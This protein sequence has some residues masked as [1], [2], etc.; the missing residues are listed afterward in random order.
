MIRTIATSNQ[1]L[2]FIMIAQKIDKSK[3]NKRRNSKGKNKIESCMLDPVR[4]I[5]KY[6]ISRTCIVFISAECRLTISPQI[7]QVFP[8]HR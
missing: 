7:A 8:D 1:L 6:S 4:K 5:V 2:Q 3:L